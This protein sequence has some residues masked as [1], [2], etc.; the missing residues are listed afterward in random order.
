MTLR[1]I[2]RSA[3]F[4]HSPGKWACVHHP[5]ARPP[6]PK[7]N[8]GLQSRRVDHADIGENWLSPSYPQLNHQPMLECKKQSPTQQAMSYGEQGCRD[9]RLA[10]NGPRLQRRQGSSGK[11][12]TLHMSRNSCTAM[13]HCLRRILRKVPNNREIRM[14]DGFTSL[15]N[16]G[17]SATNQMTL[18]EANAIRTRS[19]VGKDVKSAKLPKLAS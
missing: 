18:P 3:R 12:R 2:A 11:I 4:Q 6:R 16:T 19:Q 5:L 13:R 1:F 15:L 17:A 14:V 9:T 10:L 8:L 7:C